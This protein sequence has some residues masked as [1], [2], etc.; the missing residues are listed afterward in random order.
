MHLFKKLYQKVLKIVK[1]KNP[2]KHPALRFAS[3]S[4]FVLIS[5]LAAENLFMALS[6]RSV[7]TNVVKV[8]EENIPEVRVSPLICLGFQRYV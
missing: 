8:I 5:A 2:K 4:H 7:M 1:K 3:E 6:R